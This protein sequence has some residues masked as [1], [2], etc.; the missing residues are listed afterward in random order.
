MKNKYNL[1]KLKADV[2]ERELAKRQARYKEDLEIKFQGIQFDNLEFKDALS[3]KRVVA[4]KLH[5]VVADRLG[6]HKPALD[7][8]ISSL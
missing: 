3:P 6:H 5:Q 8:D 1:I 4:K 2:A 7:V